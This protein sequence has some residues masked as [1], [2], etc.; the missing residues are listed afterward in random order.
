[1][2]SGTAMTTSDLDRVIGILIDT[3]KKLT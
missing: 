3:H 2:P 1:L